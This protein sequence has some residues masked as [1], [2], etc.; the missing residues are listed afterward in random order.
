MVRACPFCASTDGQRFGVRRGAEFT[1]CRRCR[2]I[3]REIGLDGFDRLHAEAFE[4]DDFL[5]RVIAGRGVEPDFVAWDALALGGGRVLEIGPGSGH[6]LAAAAARQRRVSA[7]ETSARHRD[8][9]RRTWGIEAVFASLEDLP[10]DHV[11]DLVV[12]INVLEHV[13]DVRGF[14]A[15]IAEHLA[16]GGSLFVSTPNADALVCSLA[17][18]MWSMFKEPDHVSFPT[19]GGLAS[20]AG[21]AG[22][23][24]DRVWSG[25]M[26]FETPVGLGVAARDRWKERTAFDAAPVDDDGHPG[27][28][29]EVAGRGS[30]LLAD[31]SRHPLAR[32]EPTSALVARLGRA[33]T[34]KAVLRRP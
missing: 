32:Y 13:Y 30:R 5:D 20:A 15:A 22:L 4:E 31:L 26:A 8:F 11:V 10:A 2:S 33:G 27:P 1:R 6:L 12:A 3:H 28:P 14:L 18:T 21:A 16:P 25:E 19:R 23:V 17:G 9:V 7:V 29:A 24:A 34:V